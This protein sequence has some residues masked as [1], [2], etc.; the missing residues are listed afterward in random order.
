MTSYLVR[1][2][3]QDGTTGRYLAFRPF[4][5]TWGWFS[6]DMRHATPVSEAEADVLAA[7][8][9][10]NGDCVQVITDYYQRPVVNDVA[11][12]QQQLVNGR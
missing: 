5:K 8:M 6:P 3:Y 2:S 1:L 11:L 9:R 7:M 10:R 12:L 4:D